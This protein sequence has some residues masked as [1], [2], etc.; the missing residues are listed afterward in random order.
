MIEQHMLFRRH[1][2]KCCDMNDKKVRVACQPSSREPLQLFV[3]QSVYQ[4]AT[5]AGSPTY[6]LNTARAACAAAGIWA[7]QD[8]RRL[9][10]PYIRRIYRP[11]HYQ[12]LAVSFREVHSPLYEPQC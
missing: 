12:F 11:A 1:Q 2:T 7:T 9:C 6:H 10:A 8:F 3:R 4:A 5:Q